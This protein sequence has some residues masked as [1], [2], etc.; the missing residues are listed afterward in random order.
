MANPFSFSQAVFFKR[1]TATPIKQEARILDFVARPVVTKKLCSEHAHSLIFVHS[2]CI[3]CVFRVSLGILAWSWK[4]ILST[5]RSDGLGPICIVNKQNLLKKGGGGADPVD[6]T[7][8]DPGFG[9]VSD[10]MKVAAAV[11]TAS[12]CRETV[13]LFVNYTGGCNGNRGNPS[14]SATAPPPPSPGQFNFGIIN[15]TS[16]FG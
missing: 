13:S 2:F 3:L 7:V 15:T 10:A 5:Q 8:A 16:K 6:S 12:N 14:G 11:L 9:K 4:W 1:E